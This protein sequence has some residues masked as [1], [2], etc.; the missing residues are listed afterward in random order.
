ML[1]CLGK[2]ERAGGAGLLPD[3][4]RPGHHLRGLESR[5]PGQE[6]GPVS[7]RGH[8]HQRAGGPALSRRGFE[9]RFAGQRQGSPHGHGAAEE[10]RQP[11][12]ERNAQ[13]PDREDRI[14]PGSRT[15][16]GRIERRDFYS[17]AISPTQSRPSAPVVAG[18][19]G[20]AGALQPQP[21]I[22]SRR[23]DFRP[24]GNANLAFA[25]SS[26]KCSP[27]TGACFPSMARTS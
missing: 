25:R 24:R 26:P 1:P 2:T 17:R 8:H 20:Q 11:A 9:S 16:A 21:G 6:H 23:K 4:H 10:R 19:D 18:A 12:G 7:R 22:Q 15:R 27:P 14:F 3:R 5:A 13:R